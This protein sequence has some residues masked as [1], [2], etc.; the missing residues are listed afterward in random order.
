MPRINTVLG[1]VDAGEVGITA[2][3][4]HLQIGL[5]GWE[6]A[7]E[8]NYSRAEAFSRAAEAL[9]GFKGAG[10]TCVLDSSPIAMARDVE[11]CRSLSRETGV[12]VAVCTG[13]WNDAG[14]PGHFAPL[15][16]AVPGFFAAHDADYYGDL[17]FQELTLGV[18][19]RR[20]GRTEAH[21]AA[22]KVGNGPAGISEWEELIYRGAAR[23][24]RKTGSAVFTSG[25]S[26]VERQLAILQEEAVPPERIVVGECDAP[27]DAGR[28]LRLCRT[29]VCVSFDRL[30]RNGAT[31]DQ[32]AQQI[33]ALV[34][35]GHAQQVV[36]SCGSVAYP[37]AWPP[38]P[39]SLPY[40]LEGFVPQLRAAG[41]SEAAIQT[42]LVENPRRLLAF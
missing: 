17:M 26:Q 25:V 33:K 4:E 37:I 28:N 21:A 16:R 20:L 8:V 7:P 42:I 10:G 30:G 19:S 32:R 34:D 27:L 29:G 36:V 31:D 9:R 14:I 12:H 2:L 22:I 5:P 40:L 13:F 23:A 1:P 24:A 15:L 41:L 18:M 39:Q 3:Q 35:A 11:L 38:S 6:R